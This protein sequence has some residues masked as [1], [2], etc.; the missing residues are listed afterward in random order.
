MKSLCTHT[1]I[2]L[3]L[4]LVAL[5]IPGMAQTSLAQPEQTDPPA[6]STLADI[7]ENEQTRTAL[8]EDLRAL[9]AQQAGR[10]AETGQA[11]PPEQPE[12]LSLT[13]RMAEMVSQVAGDAGSRVERI[14][15]N[16]RGILTGAGTARAIDLQEAAQAAANLGIVIAAVVAAF[17]IFRGLA[18]PAFSRL[19]TWS[20][21]GGGKSALLRVAAAVVLA[22]SV[23]ALLVF[24]AYVSG[25]IIATL[26]I[27]ETGT[28]ST[29]IA[30]FLNAFL[31]IELLKA[32]IRMLFSTRYEGLRLL[33]FSTEEAAYWN[34][35]LARL[36]GF[37]G[38]GMLLA[39]PLIKA[40]LSNAL[41]QAAGLAFMLLAF[42]YAT[43]V[44]L[45]NRVKVREAIRAKAQKA[46][47]GT[48]QVL[49]RMLAR[50]WHVLAIAYFLVVL[51]ITLARPD[52][53]L[54]F[55]MLATLKTIIYIG[56]G[57]LASG[58]LSQLIGRRIT[59]SSDLNR[60]VPLLEKRLNAYVPM[61]LKIARLV[62]LITVIMFTLH[63]WG[64]FNL[65]AWY[66]SQPGR[67]LIGTLIS[68]ALILIVAL[69][70]WVTLASLI[71]H[72]LSPDTGSGEPT[73]RSK[74]LLSLFRNALAITI[75]TITFMIV[76]SEI[77]INIGP[78]IAGA[79][80]LG[81][82]IGFGAQKLVQDIITGVFIQVENA[83]NTGDVVTAGGIT[84]V[85]EKLSIRS[86]SLRDLS[87]VYHLIP[88]SSVDTVS[89]FTRDFSY[90]LGTYGIAYRED[91]DEA[92]SQ[93]RAAF[94]ELCTDEEHKDNILEPM[95]I[96]GVTA[97]GSSSV[98]LRVRIKTKPGAQWALGRAYNRLVKKHFDAAG[99]EIPFPH[100]TLYFG[101]DKD[102][103]A[104]P[105]HVRM[106]G[107]EPE[108]S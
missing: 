18:R 88:F 80:V 51:V 66:V 48:S 6:Y 61:S 81:L 46:S 22:A 12:K 96:H 70:I 28:L 95:E 4:S 40:S 90:H 32:G 29:H 36:A 60:R 47:M 69:A 86:V 105:A 20:L 100:T 82:A 103:S 15:G 17:L 107:T 74:T 54:P 30:L 37:L 104:P 75:A 57:L 83:M 42:L 44:M 52:D 5:S 13:R 98:D 41:G 43:A 77:G 65:P 19:S 56:L 87:G 14:A 16:I 27:G 78:L 31:I 73:A 89:N 25:N 8:I 11:M 101:Q 50:C 49:L 34:R 72:R 94:D 63:A 79:G 102:G 92:I 108:P 7:L 23:D 10:Q 21:H 33:P 99:I 9:A 55:V 93:L 24:L 84:G 106:L 3:L 26:A 64:L 71:E 35:F 68:L 39:A 97:L 91:I 45:R 53:A 59:L 1:F 62:I 85:A 38:Y 58:I 2:W 67:K 76:L